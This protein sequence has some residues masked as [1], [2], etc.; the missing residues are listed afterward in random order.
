MPSEVLVLNP[1]TR[2]ARIKWLFCLF[3]GPCGP[4]QVTKSLGGCIL[5]SAKWDHKHLLGALRWK[6]K[7]MPVTQ[8][9]AA[10]EDLH[11]EIPPATGQQT[12]HLMARLFRC[13]G[14]RLHV[15]ALHVSHPHCLESQLR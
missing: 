1:E 6:A 10:K 9:S 14:S 13:W 4:G 3:L 2:K 11:P 12:A 7:A 15:P 5:S 8:K